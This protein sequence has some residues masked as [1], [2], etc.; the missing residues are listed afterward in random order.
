[1]STQAQ[2]LT[3][4]KSVT[5]D[6]SPEHAFDTFTVRLANWWPLDT[7]S[8]G[9]MGGRPP[10]HA[11]LEPGVGGRLYEQMA[12]GDEHEWAKVLAWEPP[13]RFV[14]DWH[15]NPDNP[16]TEVEVTFTPQGD[17]TRVELVHRGWE[18]YG[19]R[20]SEAYGDY[21]AGWEKIL[22]RFAEAASN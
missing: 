15:V 21:G 2:D 18:R 3:I 20:A 13:S 10:R 12:D 19:D 16:S 4:R 5:V 1:M 8:V 17:G 6:C 11:V 7:H 9:G 22:A 14:M